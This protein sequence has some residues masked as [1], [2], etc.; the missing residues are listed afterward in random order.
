MKLTL[1]ERKN[2]K[3]H[4]KGSLIIGISN[5]SLILAPFK[6]SSFYDDY[7]YVGKFFAFYIFS[8]LNGRAIKGGGAAIKEKIIFFY[9]VAI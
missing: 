8:P 2:V 7:R 3:K 6:S 5:T 4:K 1:S 9:R